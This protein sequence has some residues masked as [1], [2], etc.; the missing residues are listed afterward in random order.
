MV[1]FL[2]EY[3]FSFFLGLFV[4]FFMSCVAII[5]VAPHNDSEMR[6]FT[7]CTYR[8]AEKLML[9]ETLKYTEVMSIITEGYGCYF[10]VMGEGISLFYKGEQAT[11]WANYLFKVTT[12]E[13]DD[14]A[15]DAELEQNNLFV[16]DDE[17]KD[18]LDNSIK[19]SVDE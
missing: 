14:D 3:W 9:R 15:F 19:E 6:G 13:T 8:M 1:K 4:L 12:N 2:R 11:P 16:E 10:A 17:I 7:P 5:A 18:L